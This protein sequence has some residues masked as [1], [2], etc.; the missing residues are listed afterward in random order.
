ME[1]RIGDNVIHRIFGYGEITDVEERVI[2]GTRTTCYVVKVNHDT[3]W[4]PADM[5]GRNSLRSPTPPKEFINTIKILTISPD[6]LDEDR[7]IRK[8]YLLDH[9]SDGQLTS[10]CQ[11]VRDLTHYKKIF[12]LNDQEKSIL[13]QAIKSLLEEW[14]LSLEIPPEKAQ[15]SLEEMLQT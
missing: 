1:F 7:V 14:S 15:K 10:I 5:P 9:L 3:I 12:K 4:V 11:V 13:E 8:K 2:N 6:S